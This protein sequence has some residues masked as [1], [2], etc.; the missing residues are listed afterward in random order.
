LPFF[1]VHGAGG[2][3][4]FYSDL[5]QRLGL[6]QPFFGLQAPGFDGEQ[7][8][9]KRVE[10]MAAKY[11]AEVR[12]V[13]QE[14]PYF[15]GGLSMG[16]V[17]AFEM[18]QQLVRQ[19]QKV[20]LLALLDTLRPPKFGL[21]S[22]YFDLGKRIVVDRIVDRV[23]QHAKNIIRLSAADRMAY[24]RDKTKLALAAIQ[25]A[26]GATGASHSFPGQRPL[27]HDL[28]VRAARRY[29]PT[30]YPGRVTQ[31]LAAEHPV[32]TPNDARLAWRELAGGGLEVHV[33]PGDHSAMV[34]EPN[35][36]A[37]AE[38]LRIELEASSS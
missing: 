23:I 18:A 19:G 24:L 26:L 1:M 27:V 15:L 29:R 10:D 32:T 13:Q 30:S 8:P 16:G 9:L 5:A 3:V 14:G 33:V 17:V 2:G 31:F 28:N 25:P 34:R 35:A 12:S 20:G 22:Y 37:L 38:K 36:Q 4:L 7:M 21:T 6:D 11:V